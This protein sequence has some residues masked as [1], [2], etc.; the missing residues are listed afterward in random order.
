MGLSID[1]N[2]GNQCAAVATISWRG[3]TRR[4]SLAQIAWIIFFSSLL[5]YGVSSQGRPAFF[6][7]R[8]GA[9]ITRI[10]VTLAK[11]G[12]FA[13]PYQS[14]PTGPTAHAAPA[15]VF[16]IAAIGKMF[17]IGFAGAMVLWGLNVGFLAL[18]LALLPV[19]SDRLGLGAW[20]GVLAAALTLI[21]QPYRILPEFES[22]FVGALIVILCVLTTPYFQSPSD[23]KHSVMLGFLWGAAVLSSPQCVLLLLVW[24]HFAAIENSRENLRKARRAMLVVLAG[25]A[26]A[27]VPWTIRNYQVFHALFLVRDNLGLELYTSN[28]P[29]AKPTLLE[30]LQTGCHVKTHPNANADIAIEVIQKG[31][32]EFNR[33]RLHMALAWISSNPRAFALLTGR[34]FLKFWFPYLTSLRYAIPTGILTVLSALGLA[35]MFLRNRRRAAYILAATLGV[36]P[37]IH[38]LVQF[39]A[40]YRYPIFWA[41]FLA[42]SYAILEIARG[43]RSAAH[44]QASVSEQILEPVFN[45][46]GVLVRKK[47]LEPHT[48][49]TRINVE[50]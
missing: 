6:D 45:G 46:T 39:E 33:E 48:S 9:E 47:G 49:M 10:G 4:F 2:A 26:L 8:H 23:W 18:Q 30:N 38:Y 22:L 24:P 19:L 12:S 37:L 29:C 28:N 17:G 21:V 31:E 50:F 16:L 44:L 36:Y 11:E 15:Y 13:H 20:P 7:L 3:R 43:L 14:L 25:A 35:L 1:P 40:R 42:A 27:C 34:R 41:T 32:I 5:V